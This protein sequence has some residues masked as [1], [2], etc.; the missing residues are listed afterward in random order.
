MRHVLAIVALVA[1]GLLLLLGIGQRTFLAGPAEI[2]FPV[3]T[4]SDTGYAIIDAAELAKVEGQANVVVRGDTAFVATGATRD[5]RGWVEPYSHAELTVDASTKTLQTALVAPAIVNE[6]TGEEQTAPLDP[7][8]SDLWLEERA[9][10][11]VG[12]E[13]TAN[14]TDALRVPVALRSD[15]SVI[16]ASNGTDPVPA[17]VA[18]VWAQ[19]R[20][21]PWAGPLLAAGGLLALAGGVLY[22]LAV[23]H[24]RRGLG[25]RR[26]RRGPLQGLRN[27]FSR[28]RAGTAEAPA[29]P[30]A[31]PTEPSAAPP[32]SEPTSEATV[33][34]DAPA[35]PTTETTPGEGAGSGTRARTAHSRRLALL[36][37][38]GVTLA[39]GLS[40]CSASYWPQLG[41]QPTTEKTQ[42]ESPASGIAP[43]PVTA[44]QV[45]RIIKSVSESA[46]SADEALDPQLLE[47][48]FAGDA[49]AQRKA[50]YT[51]R[52]AMPDYPVIPPIVTSEELDYQ[53]IQSTE[54]W[55]R[56]IFATVASKAGDGSEEASPSLAL[57]LRQESPH[58][59]YQVFRVIALQG[60]ISMPQAA[61]AEEGTA[62]LADD[63]ETLIMP[64]G[65]VG[66]AYAKLLQ[67]GT[68]IPE[69]EL[70]AVEGDTLLENYGRARAAKAQ[71][72]SD[73]KGQTMKFSALAYQSDQP[74]TALSTGAG[75]ALVATTVIEEQIV[76]SAGGRYKPQAQDAVTALS[77]LS[78]E[79][80][81]L[82]QKVAHQL[83][84]FVPSKSDQQNAK[85]E[86]L[87]VTSELVAAT[88]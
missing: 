35:S 3:D 81:K 17:D 58:E 43:V 27:S 18:L 23:D 68:E 50:N 49:L 29:S 55:P 63:L 11:A 82:V 21:T 73:G 70:F 80:D 33:T 15:Q 19:D 7:R 37:A 30:A 10:T 53:L 87:G 12:G 24:D 16:I 39:L 86:L 46:T 56:T 77:G 22:L 2:R 65:E 44:E 59:N 4:Q 45:S 8:G 72:D 48:R 40:G 79:Q 31:T 51:I 28:G 78:G 26:G 60:G 67:D 25:P 76:D 84:F 69:A 47:T 38:V 1:A 75:G 13:Q 74:I 5:V 61:P 42:V 6:D 64:P 83:L 20:N 9:V 52:A 62:V 88:N 66:A 32:A 57:I 14:E 34:P 85:I 36:P 41:E 54:G 71:A